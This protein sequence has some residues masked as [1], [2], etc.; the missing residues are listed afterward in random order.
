MS[1]L[2][3]YLNLNPLYS[4]RGGVTT[5]AEPLMNDPVGDIDRLKPL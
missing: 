5:L 4:T 3:L 2:I 1:P